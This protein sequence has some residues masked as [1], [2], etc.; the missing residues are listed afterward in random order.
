MGTV[1]NAILVDGVLNRG[2]R[3]IFIGNSGCIDTSISGIFEPDEGKEMKGKTKVISRDKVFAARGIMLK[4]NHVNDVLPGTKFL[5]YTDEEGKNKATVKLTKEREKFEEE[6]LLRE[7]APRGVYLNSPSFGPLEALWNICT[8]EGIP[9]AGANVG[10]ITKVE[11][12]KVANSICSDKK[13]KDGYEYSK[14]FGTIL[15]YQ[16]NASKE[17]SE[18]ATREGVTI[19]EHE[20]IYHLLDAYKAFKDNI[21][22]KI[23]ER[24]PSIIPDSTLEILPQYVFHKKDPLI[25]GVKVKSGILKKGVQIA[26]MSGY[27]LGDLI[28]I[29]KNKSSVDEAKENEEVCLKIAKVGD[30]RYEYGIH[31]TE[32]DILHNHIENIELEFKEKYIDVF[33]EN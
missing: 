12:I 7:M 25:F 32:K 13:D 16:S 29:E 31:F 26:T 8:S 21:Y 28:S 6:L 9:V 17:I 22:N 10:P 23:K 18:M 1:V 30:T 5:V 24:H 19:I 14:Q 15:N 27:I 20:I 33:E 11:L 2:D 4:I 3:A